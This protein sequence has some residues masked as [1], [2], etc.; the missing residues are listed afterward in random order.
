[1]QFDWALHSFQACRTRELS[2][3]QEF[4]RDHRRKQVTPVCGEIL[5]VFVHACHFYLAAPVNKAFKTS[6]HTGGTCL[7]QWS[8]VGFSNVRLALIKPE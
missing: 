1:M 2:A 6:P 8:R 7:R 5:E 4:T 3:E